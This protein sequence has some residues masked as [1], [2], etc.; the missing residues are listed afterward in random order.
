MCSN[1]YSLC[2]ANLVELNTTGFVYKMVVCARTPFFYGDLI[3]FDH[4]HALLRG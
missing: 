1:S 3:Q 2:E 4:E